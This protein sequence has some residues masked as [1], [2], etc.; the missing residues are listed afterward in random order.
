MRSSTDVHGRH[1]CHNM[2]LNA[3][4]LVLERILMSLSIENQHSKTSYKHVCNRVI[5][6]IIIKATTVTFFG[7]LS[8]PKLS[9]QYFAKGGWIVSLFHKGRHHL[10]NIALVS[11][12][13][14]ALCSNK[15]GHCKRTL[16]SGQPTD[17]QIRSRNMEVNLVFD[18]DKP[19]PWNK[20]KTENCID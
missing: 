1:L 10:Y 7:F 6:I 9:A 12:Q 5:I 3:S 16:F 2:K 20:A 4:L 18:D 19:N 8:Q 14:K 11:E 17:Q 15:E 13:S